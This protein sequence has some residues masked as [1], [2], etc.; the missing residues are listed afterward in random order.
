MMSHK[1]THNLIFMMTL[2]YVFETTEDRVKRMNILANP[3]NFI[4]ILP[5][6]SLPSNQENEYMYSHFC[7]CFLLEGYRRTFNFTT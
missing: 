1:I 6:C 3:D 2:H 4:I 5:K 7:H